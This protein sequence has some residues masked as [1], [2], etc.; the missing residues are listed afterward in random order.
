MISFIVVICQHFFKM[1]LQGCVLSCYL[2]KLT[3]SWSIGIHFNNK[4][5]IF[6]NCNVKT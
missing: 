4:R 6:S 5:T 1:I 3:N 2:I